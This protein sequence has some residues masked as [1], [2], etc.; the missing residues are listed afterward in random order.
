[1]AEHGRISDLAQTG[2]ANSVVYDKH[3]PA[4]TATATQTLL[5]QCRVAGKKHAKIL[6]LAAGTGKFTEGLVQRD[7]QYEVVA[8]EPHYGMREVLA[9]KQLSGVVVK[10]GTAEKIPLE[11]ASVDAVVAAQVGY[12]N[13]TSSS[14]QNPSC[15]T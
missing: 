14:W 3:R 4:Y 7:E 6:D 10:D 9:Q 12:S 13:F 1:M 5:E 8:V 2:F 11:D 15:I